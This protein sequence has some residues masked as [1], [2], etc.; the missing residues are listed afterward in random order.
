MRGANEE[1]DEEDAIIEEADSVV[2]ESFASSREHF[3]S[4][5]ENIVCKNQ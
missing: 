5:L 4:F 1:Q 3:R 2:T